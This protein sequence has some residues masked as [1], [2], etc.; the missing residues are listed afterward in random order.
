MNDHSARLDWLAG[1][2]R[3][4][5]A[6]PRTL[7]QR[8][9]PMN[10]TPTTLGFSDAQSAAGLEMKTAMLQFTQE[11]F[12][13]ELDCIQKELANDEA[14]SQQKQL[15]HNAAPSQKWPMNGLSEPYFRLLGYWTGL[16]RLMFQGS[17]EMAVATEKCC[18]DALELL[19]EQT[20][21]ITP[22]IPGITPAIPNYMLSAMEVGMGHAMAT[23]DESQRL[24]VDHA[25][26]E[27]G[28]T[29]EHAGAGKRS[30]SN[31]PEKRHGRHAPDGAAA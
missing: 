19:R 16:S 25:N 26:G 11:V 18:L 23:L 10:H 7:N 15:S 20:S 2:F 22:A 5:L 8:K 31:M 13:Y 28:A 29:Q 30:K 4:F 21:R 6:V 14:V 27:L 24:A 12:Q 17:L 3:R 1:L 9:Q